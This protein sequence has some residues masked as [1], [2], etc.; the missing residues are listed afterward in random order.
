MAGRAWRAPAR[1]WP[2]RPEV[3]AGLDLEA[4]GSWLGVNDHGVV[5]AVLNRPGT[6][7]PQ[8]GKR[9][10]GE[11]VLEALDHAEAEAAALAFSQLNADAYRS[12]NLVVA[13]PDRV[14][15]L[16]NPGD[17]GTTAAAPAIE[18]FELP[19]GLSMITAHDRNDP[20][21]PRIRAHLPRFEAAAA[22]DPD[23]GDWE[24]WRGILAS[25]LFDAADG[26]TAAMTVVTE[27]GFETTSSALIALPSTPADLAETPRRPVWLFA[28][29]RPDRVAY[30]PVEI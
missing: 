28:P 15:W 29:G 19:A 1:H 16:R 17:D 20:S 25:R 21:S 18:V 23:S 5:A 13:D 26:P 8:D 27:R 30:Q 6:L 14:F 24:A 3:T 11:L 4:G 7:G 9:S 12:F 2:D 22:P 10:R